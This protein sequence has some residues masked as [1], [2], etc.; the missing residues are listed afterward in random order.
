VRAELKP[1]LKL[2]L[3]AA[4]RRHRL[5]RSVKERDEIPTDQAMTMSNSRRIAPA[6]GR[7][8]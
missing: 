5:S 4:T 7:G 8:P 1:A 6:A 3:Q 2:Q